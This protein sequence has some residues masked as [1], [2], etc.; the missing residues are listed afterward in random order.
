[1]TQPLP[2]DF[3]PDSELTPF[4][5]DSYNAVYA[6]AAAESKVKPQEKDSEFGYWD[7]LKLLCCPCLLANAIFNIS[8]S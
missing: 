8:N 2:L 5:D 3:G 7:C 1:M 6:G 4:T